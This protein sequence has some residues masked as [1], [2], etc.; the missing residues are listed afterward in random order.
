[1]VRLIET[2]KILLLPNPE[3]LDAFVEPSVTR[4][5]PRNFRK[6]SGSTR[7]R[8]ST[9]FQIAQISASGTREASAWWVPVRHS[10]KQI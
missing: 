6:G 8:S 9:A 1:V 4:T 2:I 5:R 10:A 3:S 7:N